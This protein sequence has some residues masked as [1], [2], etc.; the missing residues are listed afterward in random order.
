MSVSLN[1]VNSTVGNINSRYV[2]AVASDS[3]PAT[4]P[5]GS[6]IRQGDIWIRLGLA[7]VQ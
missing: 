6:T 2:V 4:R 1:N 5:D 7:L 3:E